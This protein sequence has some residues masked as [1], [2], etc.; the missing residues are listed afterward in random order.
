MTI[1]TG[2]A[3]DHYFNTSMRLDPDQVNNPGAYT[4]AIEYVIATT[5]GLEP[6]VSRG[7]VAQRPDNRFIMRFDRCPQFF[8]DGLV[9]LADVESTTRADITKYVGNVLSSN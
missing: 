3:T 5:A 2:S 8:I 6:N 9:G 1:A 4:S 7:Q